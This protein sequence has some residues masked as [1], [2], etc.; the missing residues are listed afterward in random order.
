MADFYPVLFNS[1]LENP[2]TAHGYEGIY[3]VENDQCAFYE[4]FKAVGQALFEL[5]KI[6]SP[7]LVPY[8][9]E[10]IAASPLV[11]VF[12]LNELYIY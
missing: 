3:F 8:N 5:G 2:D 10:E 11:R 4:I 9:A 12:P 7:E 1:I 6:S